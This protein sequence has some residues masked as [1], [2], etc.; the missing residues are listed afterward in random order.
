MILKLTLN[1]I[2]KINYIYKIFLQIVLLN[3]NNNLF[4]K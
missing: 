4:I 1:K 3:N 2:N